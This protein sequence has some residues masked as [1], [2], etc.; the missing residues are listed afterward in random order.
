[1]IKK[2]YSR[3]LYNEKNY[4][5]N[6]SRFTKI[7]KGDKKILI[8]LSI[9]L[10]LLLLLPFLFIKKNKFR[11]TQVINNPL[12]FQRQLIG[13]YAYTGEVAGVMT[14]SFTNNKDAGVVEVK[15]DSSKLRFDI[16]ISNST[17]NGTNG[18]FFN[19]TDISFVSEDKVTAIKYNL[20][21]NGL[22][23]EIILN[24]IPQENMIPIQLKIENLK[25]KITSDGTPVFF[26]NSGKYQFNFERPFVKDG[27]GNIS[28]GVVFIF[29]N[30][31]QNK[32]KTQVGSVTRQTLLTADLE[33]KDATN[34]VVQI[35]S[36]WLHD[37][38]RVLPITIDP[39]VIHNTSSVFATGSFNRTS[40]AGGSIT[41]P[42]TDANIVGV[43]HFD[44][45]T[46]G[47]CASGKD[48]CDSSGNSLDGTSTGST[49]VTGKT[50]LARSFNGSSYITVNNNAALGFTGD[51][52]ISGW[53]YRI[54][55]PGT[56][57]SKTSTSGT[58]G[59][60]LLYGGQ[61]EVYCRTDNGTTSVDS[62]T[63]WGSVP[64]SAWTHIAAVKTGASC[65]IY[66]NGV[67]K[68]VNDPAHGINA[69]N[70]T[71]LTI[72]AR[73]DHAT[74]FITGYID[75]LKIS[76]IA[77]S[78]SYIL[79]ES[80]AIPSIRAGHHELPADQKTMGLWHLNEGGG[81]NVNDSSGYNNTGKATGTTVV[82]GLLNNARSFNGT[83]DFI[84]VGAVESMF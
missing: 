7:I 16:P 55:G 62:L 14:T 71:A 41:A 20:I 63:A 47:T 12:V 23:E 28:Y 15:R 53:V 2:Y 48:A 72:G 43:W 57:V 68:T 24:K 66:I 27:A 52:T 76:N 59:Y 38:K 5:V 50:N 82:S 19:P 31:Q 56:L 77:R 34:I 37:P 22:K 9:C 42:A 13:P 32:F 25:L 18:N 1:M 81:S 73:S 74:E 39:T 61:G 11:Q 26:D 64:T 54:S 33:E 21:P 83:S 80:Q 8:Y 84:E 60:A 69:V 4:R 67:D 79:Q 40:D 44:E 30:S 46:N 58:S 78:S 35:D 36:N 70:S 17:V 29:P 49:I 3:Q 65:R 51:F 10:G 6:F 75:E 45:S